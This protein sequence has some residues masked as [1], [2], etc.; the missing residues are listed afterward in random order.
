MASEANA[1]VVSSFLDYLRIE[2]GLAPLTIGA[3]ATDICQFAETRALAA[4]MMKEA[5]D[6]AQKLGVTFRVSIDKRIAGREYPRVE[7]LI[8]GLA[9]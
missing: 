2:K 5:Q 4:A 7:H 9:G 6:I 1:R 3:Y 8:V